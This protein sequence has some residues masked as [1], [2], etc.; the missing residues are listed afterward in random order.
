MALVL[1]TSIVHLITIHLL[2]CH[3]H[4]LPLLLVGDLCQV[5]TLVSTDL[6]GSCPVST[7]GVSYVTLARLDQVAG[8]PQ[9]EPPR[10]TITAMDRGEKDQEE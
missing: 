5:P 7:T 1:M 9:Q 2:Y 6:P 4:L 10:I 8:G 3:L